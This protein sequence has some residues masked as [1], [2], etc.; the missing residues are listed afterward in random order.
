M[1]TMWL[2]GG[3]SSSILRVELQ[4]S[5]SRYSSFLLLLPLGF[6]VLAIANLGSLT[7]PAWQ[8]ICLLTGSVFLLVPDGFEII[9][10]GAS[11]IL[12]AG[13]LP[14]GLSWLN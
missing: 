8:C 4:P 9:N 6:I 14:L 5:F 12:I 10:L 3:F 11:I 13:L 1:I 2:P 7:L